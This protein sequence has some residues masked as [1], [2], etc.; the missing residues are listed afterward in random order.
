MA[1]QAKTIEKGD[2]AKLIRML[3]AEATLVAPVERSGEVAF[4]EVS[5]P[6]EVTLDYLNTLLPPK[7]FVL[8]QI[9]PMLHYDVDGRYKLEPIYEQEKRIL[10][11]IRPCDVSAIAY[12]DY[13]F[14]EN[15]LDIYYTKRRENTTI[16]SLTCQEPGENCFCICADC[17]PFADSGFDIQLTDLGDKYLAEIGSERGAELAAKA[18][19]LFAEASEAEAAKRAELA[20]VAETRFKSTTTYF[21]AAIRHISTETLPEGL[22]EELGDRCL[23]CGGC[24]YVCPTCSCFN[25]VDLGAGGVGTRYRCWD[26]C[27]LAGFTRMAGGHNPRKEK[28]DRRNRRF[29]HKLS[30]YYVQRQ[31]RHGCVGCGRCIT[32]C[33]GGIDM[34]AV[35]KMIRRGEVPARVAAGG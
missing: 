1:Y 4:A 5:G 2:I 23:A 13:F 10:F 32:A 34:P 24:S 17:G 33:L 27:A 25:V 14:T 11:G 29:Y 31:G 16:I 19:D 9:E 28:Q 12:L 7:R 15:I 21:S 20:E 18:G 3:A 6:E 30:Y 35:V 22:W 26:S 8:P